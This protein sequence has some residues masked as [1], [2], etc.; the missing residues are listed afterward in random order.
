METG[1][2]ITG[3]IGV[4][5]GCQYL[6]SN[7]FVKTYFSTFANAGNII[8]ENATIM[9][10]NVRYGIHDDFSVQ[11]QTVRFQDIRFIRSGPNY[12]YWRRAWQR[13]IVYY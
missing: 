5:I 4:V 10:G 3:E 13:R 2:V 9:F 8:L 7:G 12:R 1:R 6:G 11:D